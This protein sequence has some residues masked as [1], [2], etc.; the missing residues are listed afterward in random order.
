MRFLC[1]YCIFHII[2]PNSFCAYLHHA[3]FAIIMFLCYSYNSPA[4]NAFFL[5]FSVHRANLIWINHK[6]LCVVMKIKSKFA[7]RLF[8]SMLAVLLLP[9]CILYLVY[10]QHIAASV[11]EEVNKMIK[12]EQT[13][14]MRLYNLLLLFSYNFSCL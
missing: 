5:H 14:A 3:S 8:A 2:Y 10:Q 1:V 6:E 7:L 11:T 9:I 13:A 12:N 4:Q